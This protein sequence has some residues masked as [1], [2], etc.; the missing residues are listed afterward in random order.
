MNKIFLSS[1]LV[2]LFFSSSAIAGLPEMMK[3]Y[4]NPKLAPKLKVCKGDQNCNAVMALAKQWNSIPNNYRYKG[5]WDIKSYARK[6]ITWDSQGRN[7]GLHKGFYLYKDKS[8]E[9][10]D[11]LY[12]ANIAEPYIERSWAVLLYIE[13]KNGW[14]K[15]D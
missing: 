13:D 5:E 10:L 12:D 7:I 15:P 8:H 6:G 11:A 1:A 9:Y 14:V 2:A 4:N 3:L